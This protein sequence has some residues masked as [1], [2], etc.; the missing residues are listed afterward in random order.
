[1]IPQ[2]SE[3]C[4]ANIP[5][6]VQGAEYKDCTSNKKDLKKHLRHRDRHGRQVENMIRLFGSY[7]EPRVRA[8][9]WERTEAPLP[10]P[11]P[12][13]NFIHPKQLSPFTERLKLPF[14][15]DDILSGYEDIVSSGTDQLT[16]GENRPWCYLS[17][18][19]AWSMFK[20]PLQNFARPVKGD[21]IHL[22]THTRMCHIVRLCKRDS[23]STTGIQDLDVGR[24]MLLRYK[25]QATGMSSHYKKH[26][27]MSIMTFLQI[28]ST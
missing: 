3:Q 11:R 21:T 25:S 6:M 5:T 4:M 24:E 18:T 10:P 16:T 7:L 19:H 12:R 15:I 22:L 14:P 28:G 23:A 9:F 13:C 8:S 2:H 20:K 26:V 17:T 27:S 1:M